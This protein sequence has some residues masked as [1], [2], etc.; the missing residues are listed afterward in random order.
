MNTPEKNS[1]QKNSGI[2]KLKP[3]TV[4]D[5]IEVTKTEKSTLSDKKFHKLRGQNNS[6]LKDFTKT[7]D[8]KLK[9]QAKNSFTGIF[10]I[11]R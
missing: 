10:K 2:Q 6:K 5:I 7:Q 4:I 3:K 1:W 11:N 8:K 9:T